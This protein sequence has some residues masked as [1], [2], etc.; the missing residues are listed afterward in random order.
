MKYLAYISNL[1]N[2]VYLSINVARLTAHIK[3][4]NFPMCT[5]Y[6]LAPERPTQLSK[7][8]RCIS[9][10]IYAC[11]YTRLTVNKKSR[12]CVCVHKPTADTRVDSRQPFLSHKCVCVCE[13]TKQR[14]SRRSKRA[15]KQRQRQRQRQQRRRQR[16][17][18]RQ[19]QQTLPELRTTY[20]FSAKPTSCE[21]GSSHGE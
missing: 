1:V 17:R 3:E 12:M 13:L 16:Q 2:N 19:Q 7:Y 10:C 6:T 21:S 11:V 8:I 5:V 15:K 9:V 14:N 20:T 4:N 18:Q